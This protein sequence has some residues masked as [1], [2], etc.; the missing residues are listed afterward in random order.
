MTDRQ[1]PNPEV[2][3][4]EAGGEHWTLEIH[5][6]K[7]F[8]STLGA[9]V[10]T[11]FVRCFVHL[12]RLQSLVSF[13]FLSQQHYMSD[14]IPF[15]RNLQ[16]MVWFTVG[17]LRELGEAVQHLRSALK[18]RGILDPESKH[19][20]QL[21]SLETRWEDDSFYRKMRDTVAFHV[22]AS[23]VENG[24]TALEGQHTVVVVE[25][26][27]PKSEQTSLRMGLEA[28]FMGSDKDK[29]DFT[30]FITNVAEDHGIGDAI[31]SAFIDAVEKAG[32][33]CYR[34]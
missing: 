11:A 9:E 3:L 8:R 18:K 30:K 31:Q 4:V 14:S 25:A 20:V 5:H 32:I 21:R 15:K 26:E 23:V 7:E 34:T 10:L 27:G 33:S 16:T 2:V 24:L 19:W 28:V 29:D 6:Y 1:S 12:D 13:Q 22:D 17:T